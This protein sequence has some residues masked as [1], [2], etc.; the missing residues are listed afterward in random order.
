MT[1]EPID[2]ESAELAEI[3]AAL[4]RTAA[5]RVRLE[6]QIGTVIRRTEDEIARLDGAIANAGAERERLERLT[7]E[8]RERLASLRRR[9]AEI[10]AM[11]LRFP[12]ER[13]RLERRKEE[14][15]QQ[16][17]HVRAEL[18]RS[19]QSIGRATQQLRGLEQR[20]NDER[21]RLKRELEAA[22]AAVSAKTTE[23]LD[24]E[25]KA[26]EQSALL[27]QLL[28][29]LAKVELAAAFRT[30]QLERL[31]PRGAPGGEERAHLERWALD[32]ERSQENLRGQAAEARARFDELRDAVGRAAE[33]RDAAVVRWEHL[34]QATQSMPEQTARDIAQTE[35]MIEGA[36]WLRHRLARNVIEEEE[37]FQ[38]IGRE[39]VQFEVRARDLAA[40]R[41][42]LDQ[43]VAAQEELNRI[44]SEIVRVEAAIA[45]GVDER[46]RLRRVV[47]KVEAARVG[48]P[49]TVGAAAD[50]ES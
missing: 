4:D 25:N 48:L 21:E 43:E 3:R 35:G 26:K 29:Q 42:R 27:D 7:E 5:E 50:Q 12:E 8:E 44:Q 38:Q 23:H 24:L 18:A 34:V 49:I 20:A 46:D 17:E 33:A 47:A 32:A 10:D 36:M 11:L 28:Q 1:Q 19:E 13:D 9:I 45:N 16:I 6:R 41:Q 31:Y 30:S 14:Q 39:I 15:W 22:Q 37:R 2:T 40:E